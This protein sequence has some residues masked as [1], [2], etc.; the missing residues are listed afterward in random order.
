[1]TAIIYNELSAKDPEW[2][3]YV[4]RLAAMRVPFAVVGVNR[5][6]DSFC[7]IVKDRF[8]FDTTFNHKAARVDFTPKDL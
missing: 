2:Q 1:M 4:V 8:D 3:R 6:D 5:L 7:E